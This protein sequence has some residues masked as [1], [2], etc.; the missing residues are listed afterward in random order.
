MYAHLCITNT[1][2]LLQGDCQVSTPRIINIPVT[3]VHFQKLC[4]SVGQALARPSGPLI[5][6]TLCQRATGA[7]IATMVIKSCAQGLS[8]FIPSL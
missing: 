7:Y 1:I 3:A 2:H 5:V 4:L 6:R 8:E